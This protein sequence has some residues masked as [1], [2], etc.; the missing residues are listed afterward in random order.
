MR[1]DKIQGILFDQTNFVDLRTHPYFRMRR[2][3]RRA[4]KTWDQ[5]RWTPNHALKMPVV[6]TLRD[7]RH[8]K[9]VVDLLDRL[10]KE[11]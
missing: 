10:N 4:H 9:I 2:L 5:M 7:K 3:T 11:R 8:E 6:S 1:N